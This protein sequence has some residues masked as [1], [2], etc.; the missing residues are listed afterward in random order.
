MNRGTYLKNKKIK[1]EN[2]EKRY[3]NMSKEEKQKLK[4]F[5]KNY[6]DVKKFQSNNQ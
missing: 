3:C 5:Q 1:R 2:M 6:C 4:E